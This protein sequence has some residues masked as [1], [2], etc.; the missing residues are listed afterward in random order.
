MLRILGCEKGAEGGWWRSVVQ[1][2]APS[3]VSLTP[4]IHNLECVGRANID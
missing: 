3:L 1:R 4:R 2:Q